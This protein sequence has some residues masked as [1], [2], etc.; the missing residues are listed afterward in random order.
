MSGNKQEVI[1][2]VTGM[3]CA[4][5]ARTIEQTLKKLPEVRVN[6]AVE[7]AFVLSPLLQ[8]ENDFLRIRLP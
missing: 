7:Q 1:I 3:H 4:A 8:G 2:P 6:F 5:C